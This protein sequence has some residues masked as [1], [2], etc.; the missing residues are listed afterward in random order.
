MKKIITALLALALMLSLASCVTRDHGGD[1]AS[2]TTT[3]LEDLFQKIEDE[4][5]KDQSTVQIGEVKYQLYSDHAEVVG[6]DTP[7]GEITIES[8]YEGKPVT[9]IADEAFN[10]IVTMTS[11]I[12]PEGVKTVGNKAFM[13]CA[14]L[15]GV[16]L[17]STLESIGNYGFYGCVRLE[18][19][20]LPASL[21]SLGTNAFGYC[22]S[23]AEIKVAS[24]SAAFAAED[25]VLFNASKTELICYP[26]GRAG[27][28]Y[29]VP[30]GVKTLKNFAF[31]NAML[32]ESVSM[33][34]VT[35]IGDY[36]F[37]SCVK[38][39]AAELGQ[40]LKYL[41][42]GTFQGCAELTSIV[43]P[44]GVESIGYLDGTSEC[45]A[46]FCD[47]TKLT[48]VTLPASLK[49]VYRRAFDGCTALSIVNYGGT[50]AQWAS[51]VIGEENAPLTAAGVVT[52][53]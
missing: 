9:A 51:V 16:V 1:D 30:A 25:G 50:S 29:T 39:S 14:Q 34:G 15:A 2:D 6:C 23:L 44:E 48:T 27:A 47:C 40:G 42:A 19:V 41:G 32:L 36:T 43:I 11:V 20:E 37:R 4:L 18:S 31:S 28:S 46:T 38:L 53:G 22:K 7:I 26:A 33:S 49:N 35:S 45:G 13:G 21:G 52:N 12:I 8:E 5:N 3:N 10:G 24:G 17:P